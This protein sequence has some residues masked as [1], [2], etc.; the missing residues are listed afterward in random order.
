MKDISELKEPP[1][2]LR[3]ESNHFTRWNV[4]ITFYGLLSIKYLAP[5]IWELVPQSIR[6]YKTLSSYL[7]FVLYLCIWFYLLLLL[8]LLSFFERLTLIRHVSTDM[9]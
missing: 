8:L 4:K 3:S 6:K 7:Y 1:Y 9:R 5:Q 2:N